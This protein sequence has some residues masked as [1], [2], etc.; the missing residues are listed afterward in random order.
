MFEP[1]LDIELILNQEFT[2][3][4]L[5]SLIRGV[6][7]LPP[8]LE[9]EL[10][11]LPDALLL[12]H[13]SLVGISGAFGVGCSVDV[14]VELTLLYPVYVLVRDRVLYDLPTFNSS[15]LTP[16][17]LHEFLSTYI[18]SVIYRCASSS[19]LRTLSIRYLK[20]LYSF[21]L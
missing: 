6:P 3:F 18:P 13:I 10:V 20:S 4:N 1:S 9:N 19:S 21:L 2:T 14:H 8:F 16:T 7:Q 15:T 12:C 11:M 17:L 5:L